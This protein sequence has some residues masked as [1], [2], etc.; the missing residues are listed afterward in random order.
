MCLFRSCD[1]HGNVTAIHIC[2]C[3][4]SSPQRKTEEEV[5]WQHPWWLQRAWHYNIWGFKTCYEWNKME[6]HCMPYG[7]WARSVNF[8]NML[9]MLWSL[10]WPSGILGRC[11]IDLEFTAGWSAGSG[12]E[13]RLLHATAED[14]TVFSDYYC[15]QRTRGVLLSMHCTNL[16]WHLIL[17]MRCAAHPTSLQKLWQIISYL[18]SSCLLITVLCLFLWSIMS[19]DCVVV[20]SLL[21]LTIYCSTIKYYE[22]SSAKISK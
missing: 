16:I 19:D 9:Q 14:D 8:Y 12:T 18:T 1:P 10:N 21:M 22:N 2:F 11:P 17:E 5:V 4:W 13:F 6:E 3:T 20:F 15:I 7:L